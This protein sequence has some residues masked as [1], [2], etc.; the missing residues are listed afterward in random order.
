FVAT[1]VGVAAYSVVIGVSNPT[2][3]IDEVVSWWADITNIGTALGAPTVNFYRDGNF[4]YGRTL[5]P[6]SPGETGR[7]YGSSFSL[8]TP[9]VHTLRVEADAAYDE[10][11]IEVI[12]VGADI[13]LSNL[14]ITPSEVMVDETVYIG[15]T[16][17]NYGDASG[18]KVIE[19]L[20][21]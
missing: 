17:T 2:P 4:L 6:I 20:V 12:G 5:L 11:T 9:G 14:T 10:I 1:E 8:V 21:S 13:R 16:A 18:S 7:T 19:C 15:V 3:A